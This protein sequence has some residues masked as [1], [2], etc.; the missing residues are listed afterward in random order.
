MARAMNFLLSLFTA[1]LLHPGA[2]AAKRVAI[3]VG[4]DAYDNL[5]AGA[6]CKRPSTTAALSATL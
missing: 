4:I 1:L 6:S 3:V 5:P 2:F